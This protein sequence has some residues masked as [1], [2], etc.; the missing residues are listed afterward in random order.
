MARCEICDYC[1]EIG[2]SLLTDTSGYG[3]TGREFNIDDF[4]NEWGVPSGYYWQKTHVET[5]ERG[6]L[7]V[8]CRAQIQQQMNEWELYDEARGIKKQVDKSSKS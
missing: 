7:C 3:E 5:D 2:E 1:D 8:S 6:S 4:E